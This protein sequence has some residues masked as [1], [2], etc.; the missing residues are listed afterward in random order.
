MN[1]KYDQP[2]VLKSGPQELKIAKV[3]TGRA[4]IELEDGRVILV[5]IVGVEGAWVNASNPDAVD[6]RPSFTV[7]MV[8]PEFQVASAPATLQ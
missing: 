2:L 1:F 6:V 3:T 8:R 4:T 7:Q 5:T